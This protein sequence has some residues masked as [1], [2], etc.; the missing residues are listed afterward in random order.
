M[1]ES[2]TL[3]FTSIADATGLDDSRQVSC[4]ASVIDSKALVIDGLAC[5][6]ESVARAITSFEVTS[7]REP[8]IRCSAVSVRRSGLGFSVPR[9]AFGA[10]LQRSAFSVRKKGRPGATQGFGVHEKSRA[11]RPVFP[12]S[13]LS[14]E[15]H[16]QRINTPN[17]FT[18][19]GV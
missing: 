16:T 8:G 1:I 15:Y 19:F 6:I 14:S 18:W 2:I 12:F 17:I 9:S 11:R 3:V 7:G 4:E 10:W 5:V 13:I